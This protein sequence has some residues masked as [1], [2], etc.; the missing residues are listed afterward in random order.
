MNKREP[1]EIRAED[2]STFTTSILCNAHS[3][4][5]VMAERM[6]QLFDG[7][8]LA[9]PARTV[10]MMPGQTAAIHRAVQLAEQGEVLVAD[11]AA[12]LYFGS[13][14]SIL[15][16]A[17]MERGITGLVIDGTVRDSTK[18]AELG[19]P[20]FCVGRS[21]AVTDNSEPGEVG[22]EIV[23]G[24][25][26]VKP[27]DYIVGDGDG[28]VVIPKAMACEVAQNAQTVVAR[29]EEIRAQLRAGKTTYEILGL[30]ELYGD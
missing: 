15:A 4:V 17:C 24:E 18:I 23:C 16:S 8:R 13:F 14:D 5:R 28:V 12:S 11:V 10:W 21:P 26:S 7:A 29:E 27:G 19:F 22:I 6:H 1:G 25:V 20:V 30:S 3:A 2:L 9:G